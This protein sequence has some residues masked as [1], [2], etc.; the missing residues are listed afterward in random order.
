MQGVVDMKLL[1]TCA[2]EGM[3]G[4]LRREGILSTPTATYSQGRKQVSTGFV[5]DIFQGRYGRSA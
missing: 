5:E 2:L 4:K 3:G 1:C